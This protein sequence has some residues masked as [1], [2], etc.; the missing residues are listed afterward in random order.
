MDEKKTRKRQRWE[1][2]VLSGRI[3]VPMMEAVLDVVH[4]GSYANVT[5]YLRDIVRKDL[6]V[7]GVKL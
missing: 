6:E 5:D 4:E 2:K 3:S 7:R 1:T